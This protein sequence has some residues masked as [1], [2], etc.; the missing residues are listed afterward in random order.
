MLEAAGIGIG[1]SNP[2]YDI[3]GFCDY[4]AEPFEEDGLWKAMKHFELI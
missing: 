1:I 2:E 4:M 3:S